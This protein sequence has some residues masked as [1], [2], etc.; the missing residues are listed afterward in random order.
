M[1]FSVIMPV[2]GVEKYLSTA[3][4]C[5]LA[6][7]FMDFE[8]ILVDDC[9]PDGCPQI[10][11]E[12]AAR[13]PRIKVVHKPQNEGLGE[14]RNT[15]LSVAQGRYVFFMDS[16]DFISRELLKKAYTAIT[17]TTQVVVFGFISQYE[18]Q[19]G[20][21]T[22]AEAVSPPAMQATSE[23]GIG[24]AFVR[25]SRA[26]VFQYA[27]NKVYKRAFLESIGVTFERTELIEDFLFNIAVFDRA[28]DVCSI[29]NT[30]YY[31]RHPTHETLATKYSPAFFKLSKRKY[32]LEED[33]L[34]KKD[35]KTEENRQFVLENYIKHV[36]S[37][38]IRNR[39]KG[40]H[41]SFKRQL[42]LIR[43]ALDDPLT[44]EVLSEYQP[45]G[46]FRAVCYAFRKRR[47]LLC[48]LL[49]LGG[50]VS[51]R[52]KIAAKRGL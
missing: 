27:W 47:V 3:I 2:Y 43:E 17:P 6:Q 4:E 42:A 45:V 22:W 49:A 29:P 50:T 1:T 44:R 38:F 10:C 52:L 33:F 8:L 35:V 5:V 46:K 14:A 41:L 39:S 30:L 7:S 16:D 48:W 26:R 12:Y 20:V 51:Q 31:Y 25:L 23:K 18:N 9:S 15:G 13:D 19:D 24:G 21:T 11:D 36:L 34:H 40:A 28:T 37:T 32:L